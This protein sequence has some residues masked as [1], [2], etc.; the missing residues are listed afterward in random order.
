MHA[1]RNTTSQGACHLPGAV[2]E[3]AQPALGI[4]AVLGVYPALNPGQALADGA[5]R[6]QHAQGAVR[7]GRGEGAVGV[8]HPLGHGWGHQGGQVA[9]TTGR[10]GGRRGGML[11]A[12]QGG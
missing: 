8:D 12:W 3:G 2:Q 1:S 5:V 11:G 7:K 4:A 10:E 6:M 9:W